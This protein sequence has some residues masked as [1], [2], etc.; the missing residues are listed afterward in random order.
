MSSTPTK[1]SLK[2]VREC[3]IKKDFEKALELS[4]NLLSFDPANYHAHVFAGVS[5]LKQSL[6][7]ESERTYRDAIRINSSNPLAWQGLL[8]L[9]EK[10]GN[11]PGMKDAS[12]A[13][14]DIYSQR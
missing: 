9:F 5:L 11:I 2:A 1:S 13:L 10:T 3:I 6:F 4:R 8:D 12:L 14:A 7:T